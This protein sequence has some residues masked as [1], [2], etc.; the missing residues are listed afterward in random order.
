MGCIT[1]GDPILGRNTHVATYFDVHQG[2]GFSPAAIWGSEPRCNR[3]WSRKL[4]D[5]DFF[6]SDLVT[7][8][9]LIC[10]FPGCTCPKKTVQIFGGRGQHFVMHLC[11]GRLTFPLLPL[12]SVVPCWPVGLKGIDL[13]GHI[14]S[15]VSTK[16]RMEVL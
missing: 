14:F 16:K 6:G 1:Y 15:F 13:T 7:L 12:G 3:L 9:R 8:L 2:F 11:H 5:V 10:F 4:C